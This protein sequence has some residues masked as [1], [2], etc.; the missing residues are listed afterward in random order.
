MLLS[1]DESCRAAGSPLSWPGWV[2]FNSRLIMSNL[3]TSVE[4]KVLC[5]QQDWKCFLCFTVCFFF[6]F[7]SHN[8]L[9]LI[10][11]K[12][13]KFL[14]VLEARPVAA[15]EL[16]LLKMV[17]IIWAGKAFLTCRIWGRNYGL[18]NPCHLTASRAVN[19]CGD[20]VDQWSDSCRRYPQEWALAGLWVEDVFAALGHAKLWLLCYLLMGSSQ[21]AQPVSATHP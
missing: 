7:K 17:L 9:K 15:S 6:F 20:S 13:A 5:V 18:R 1:S 8:H 19:S 10:C 4:R 3:E 11:L 14:V 21:V 16:V 2:L 12:S